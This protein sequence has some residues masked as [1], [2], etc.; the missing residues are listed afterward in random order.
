LVHFVWQAGGFVHYR[1]ISRDQAGWHWSN[2]VDTHAPSGGRDIGPAIAADDRGIHIVTPNGFYSV[3]RDRGITWTTE[4]LPLPVGTRVKSAS[5]TADQDGGALI[6]VSLVVRDPASFEGLRGTGGYWGLRVI[7][8]TQDGVWSNLTDP[9]AGLPE[10]APPKS[11]AE[12][13]VTDWTRIMLDRSGGVHLT[14]HGTAVSRIFA[15]DRSY[16]LWRNPSG[17]WQRPVSLRDPDP[18]AGFG[19]SYAPSLTMIGDT[20]LPLTFYDVFSGERDMGRDAEISQ[21]RHGQ[22]V[23]RS[24]PVTRYAEDAI[25]AGQP[26]NAM[27]DWFPAASPEVYRSADGR[28]WLDVLE[29]LAPTG[30]TGMPKLIVWQ[31][32]EVTR[33]VPEQ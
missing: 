11:T 26:A 5:V 1:T 10:W 16:Y 31:R 25:E 8:R 14:F 27:S 19:F 28:Q 29:T 15:N 32:L 12:D 30:V 4:R 6:A 2:E 24:L 17:A 9:L 22:R 21:F 18:A 7:H 20:A 13:V 23:R 33:W 3:S